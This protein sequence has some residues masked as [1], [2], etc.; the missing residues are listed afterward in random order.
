MNIE[1]DKDI[2]SVTIQTRLIKGKASFH[3]YKR[4]LQYFIVNDKIRPTKEGDHIL[5]ECLYCMK[6]AITL[7]GDALDQDTLDEEGSKLLDWAMI[8][9]LSTD[10]KLNSCKRCLLCRCKKSLKKSHIWP[11]FILK[12]PDKSSA[13]R[14]NIFGLHKHILK[15]SGMCTYQML[16]ERCEE[17]LSQNGEND[18]KREFPSSGDITYSMWL[19]NYCCGLIFRCLSTIVQFPM[20][21]NDDH[22]YKVLLLCRKHL[23][24]LPVIIQKEVTSLSDREN[25]QLEALADRLKG[26]DL[27]I[28]LFISPLK[29]QQNYYGVFQIPYPRVSV[30]LS[31]NKQLDKKWLVFNGSV[32]FL[33]LCC[34]PITL[35][36]PFD[37]SKSSLVNRGF[38]LRSN[39]EESDQKYTIP[40][41]EECVKLLPMGVWAMM[42]QLTEGTFDDFNAVSRFI[43][44][45]TKTPS[46]KYIQSPSMIDPPSTVKES[47]TLFQVSFLPKEFEIK[48]PHL[49]LPRNK[50]V[51][52][53]SDH[54]IITHADLTVPMLNKILTFLLCIDESKPISDCLYVIF[55]F[56]NYND[57]TMFTEGATVVVKDNKL[58]VTK[59]LSQKTMIDKLRYGFPSLQQLLNRVL[60]NKQFENIN[61]LVYLV[62]S[63]R[64]VNDY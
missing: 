20:H 63:R 48:S 58:V 56:Q 53:P 57:H 18:F 15:S 34:G 50:S 59:Y 62:N 46:L 5:K 8:D 30:A 11:N 52:L 1:Q 3:V 19:Y 31:R 4:K 7:L 9:C 64:Y 49:D 43:S 12:D 55:N 23:L 42:D 28:F 38:H 2:D 61:L 13:D 10:N 26:I 33:L 27:D 60:P 40:S 32:H 17:L 6:E 35:I 25:R 41:Q 24:S 54:K 39:P 45:T 37:Q 44:D 21:F 16:C 22:V 29:S 51:I 36:V 14:N 47:T